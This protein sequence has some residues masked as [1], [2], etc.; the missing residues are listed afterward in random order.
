MIY[1]IATSQLLDGTRDEFLIAAQ[2]CVEATRLEPGCISYD[3]NL[4][5]SDPLR[6]TFVERW[7]SREALNA[8]FSAPHFKTFRI[9]AVECIASRKVEIIS[10]ASVEVL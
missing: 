1:V 3:L 5:T 7:D 4:S 2:I 6:V 8:H 9:T 10:P